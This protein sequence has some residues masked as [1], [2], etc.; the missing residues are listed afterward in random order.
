[1][2]S[3]PEPVLLGQQEIGAHEVT[4]ALDASANDIRAMQETYDFGELATSRVVEQRVRLRQH[5][6][7]SRVLGHYQHRCAFCGLDA[8][9]LRGHRLLVASHIKPWA[10]SD[11]RERLD[12]RNGVAACAI[13]DSAFDTG[14]LTV[15]RDLAIRRASALAR[16]IQPDTVADRLFGPETVGERLLVPAGAPGPSPGFL[17][18]HRRLIFQG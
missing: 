6:F 4:L 17:D 18:Y 13:H 11:N 5:C 9:R 10:D 8:S 15:Q 12:P 7:A 14:L 16:L 2:V 1:M 3:G